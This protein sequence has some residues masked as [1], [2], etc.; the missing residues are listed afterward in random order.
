MRYIYETDARTRV[1]IYM[2]IYIYILYKREWEVHGKELSG[3]K[4]HHSF[5]FEIFTSIQ[6]I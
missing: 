6:V 2:H 1:E 4:F 3:E 5:S